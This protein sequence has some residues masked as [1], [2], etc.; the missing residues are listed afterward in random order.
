MAIWQFRLILIPERVLLSKYD[1]LPL[2][3]PED[4]AEDFPWWSD[5]QPHIGFEQQIDLIL[6]EMASWSKSQRMWGQKHRDDAHV[7]YADETK[8]KVEQ[9]AFRIDASAISLEL[10]R[11]IC[12]LARQLGCVL[13]TADYEI[14]AADESMVFAAVNQSTARKYID[15]PVSTLLSLGKPE[16]QERFNRP[17]NKGRKPPR[18]NE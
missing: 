3:I 4:L 1:V 18:T 16:I 15:D 12:L 5:V 17:M 9:I 7:L 2:A 6:P 10:V 8:N 14:L 11:R 13:M